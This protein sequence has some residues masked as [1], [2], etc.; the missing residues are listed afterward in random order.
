MPEIRIQPKIFEEYP[1]FRR[2]IVIAKDLDN[3]DHSREL[4]DM[5]NQA[6]SQA[7]Q[8]PIVIRIK[9]IHFN[10]IEELFEI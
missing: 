6:I 10:K 5:L 9:Y 2:G 4:E 8:A 7:A 1:T 3:H